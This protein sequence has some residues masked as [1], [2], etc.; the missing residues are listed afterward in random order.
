MNIKDEN[1]ASRQVLSV[2]KYGL[3]CGEPSVFEQETRKASDMS[4]PRKKKIKTY[5]TGHLSE[6]LWV[7]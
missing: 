5:K 1:G 3:L 7:W 2:N 4:N 6:F